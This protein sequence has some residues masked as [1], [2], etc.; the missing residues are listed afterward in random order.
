MT[1]G[2]DIAMGLRAAYLLMHHQ[3]NSLLAPF[4]TT[5]DQ[6]VL[7]SL[8]A[9]K[10]GIT[11]QELTRRASS[12]PNTT[13]AMLVRMENNGIITR[14]QLPTDGWAHMVRLT[15]VGHPDLCKAVSKN[16]AFTGCSIVYVSSKRCQE[17]DYV[18]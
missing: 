15:C 5:A 17:I 4:E 6:F 12:D 14:N 3:T 18:S 8:L 2:Y 1:A 11:Q 9:D 16:Q 10:D 13:R 7:L